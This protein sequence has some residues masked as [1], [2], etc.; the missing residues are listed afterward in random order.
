MIY[1][2]FSFETMS[3]NLKKLIL[4]IENS[5]TILLLKTL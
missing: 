1:N 3:N 4:R 5:V 2:N